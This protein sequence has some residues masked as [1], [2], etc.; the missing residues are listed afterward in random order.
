MQGY[1]IELNSIPNQAFVPTPIL[2]NDR[3]RDMINS[4]MQAFLSKHIIE[5]VEYSQYEQF[6]SNIFIRPKKD[7]SVRVILNLKQFNENI[8]KI[9]FKMETLKSAI[10]IIQQNDYFA[11][12]D[13]KDAYYSVL[14]HQDD[15]KYLRFMWEGKHYQFRSLP[16]GLSCSPRVFTKLLKPTFAYLRSMGHSSIPY[17]DDSLLRAKTKEQC[18]VNVTETIQLLDKLGFTVHPIKSVFDPVQII[19]FLGFILNSITMRVMVTEE[20]LENLIK[21]GTTIISRQ[22]VT[23]RE[24]AQLIGKMVACEPGMQYAPLYY[25]DLEHEKDHHL[26]QCKGN[27]DAHIVIS[28][29]SREMISAFLKYGKNAYKPITREAPALT[30]YTDSSKTGWGGAGSMLPITH[31]Q[32]GYGLNKKNLN[33]L[34]Y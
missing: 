6:Y 30:L 33:I 20:R 8:D 11:S 31:T 1:R 28:D 18:Q 34:T 3:E 2:F 22:K 17:I 4:E 5:E 27:Y 10:A 25:K 9:H 15:R 29:N 12:I 21:L 26:K 32:M 16:Q 24:F 23:I 13:L 14:V 19:V 7:E